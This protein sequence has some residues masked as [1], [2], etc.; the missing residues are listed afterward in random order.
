MK[1]ASDEYKSQLT[2]LMDAETK[3]GK[4][5]AALTVREEI[6]AVEDTAPKSRVATKAALKKSLENT[7]WNWA[8]EALILRADGI[9]T[10]PAWVAGKLVTTWEV[11]DRRTA[12]ISIAKGR[13]TNRI[14]VLE[15]SETLDEFKGFDF[16]GGKLESK[17]RLPALSK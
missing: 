6:K 8:D 11:V 7:R 15:F 5:D 9:A 14:A 3:A 13:D 17:K 10:H 1:E 4:L 12:I 2:Q 16:G